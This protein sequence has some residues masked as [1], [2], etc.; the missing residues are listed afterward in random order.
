[1]R[2]GSSILITGKL[3]KEREERDLKGD[4]VGDKRRG[5]VL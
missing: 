2:E 4:G 1:M 5:L 3:T